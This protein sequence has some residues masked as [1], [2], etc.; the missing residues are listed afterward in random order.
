MGEETTNGVLKPADWLNLPEPEERP[1]ES[2]TV[3]ARGRDWTFEIY[4]DGEADADLWNSLLGA[5]MFG[6]TLKLQAQISKEPF[7]IK[8]HV[9]SGSTV[10]TIT[11]K[12]ETYIGRVKVLSLVLKSPKASFTEL[13]IL[14]HKIGKVFNDV[15]Q[16]AASANGVSAHLIASFTEITKN[17]PGPTPES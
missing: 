2:M 13:L 15:T 11:V 7:G 8:V 6:E 16:W 3:N 12:D 14:G 9:P 17:L 5:M 4:T 1:T 10:K